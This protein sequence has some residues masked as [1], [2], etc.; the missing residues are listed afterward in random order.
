MEVEIGNGGSWC[1]E[2]DFGFK[3]WFMEDA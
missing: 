2:T 1:M 3:V